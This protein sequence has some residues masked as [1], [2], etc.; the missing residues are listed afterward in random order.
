MSQNDFTIANQTFP[1]TRADI[2][3]ALQALASNNSGASAPST[4]FANQF[5]YKTGDNTLYIRNEGNDADITVMVLDQ[6][7]DTVE[8][9][10]SDSIRTALIEFTDGDD[11]LAIADGG[12]LTTAGNLSIGGSNNELRFYE[13]ANYVGFEAPALSADKIW[14]LP[15]ADGTS[16]QALVTNGSGTLS[17]ADSGGGTSARI[18]AKPMIINGSMEINQRGTI[19]GITGAG[20]YSV[21]MIRADIRGGYGITMSQEADAPAG[22]GL[23]KSVKLDITTADTS[24]DANGLLLWNYHFEGQDLN[25]LNYGHATAKTVTVAFWCKSN[26]TGTF[27]LNLRNQDAYHIGSLVTISVANT[28]EKKVVSFVGDTGHS[29]ASNNTEG[30]R[31]QFFLNGGS[32]NIDGGVPST[33]QSTSPS[34]KSYNGT[35]DLGGSTSDNFF[36]TGLQMEVGEYTASDMPS[37]Q[38][39]TYG[40]N[41]ARC[42]RYCQST[43]SQGTAIGSATAVGIQIQNTNTTGPGSMAQGVF[44][45][46]VMRAV[47]TIVVHNQSGANTG[48]ARR[49]DT[50]GLQGLASGNASTSSIHFEN[51]GGTSANI[52]LQWQFSA[53][54]TI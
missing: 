48:N 20:V 31:V 29:L 15:T 7:N 34:T 22:Y 51:S 41:L 21:D 3:S 44:L 10:K 52:Q 40:E 5:F 45:R 37:F 18:N 8:Y 35:I 12:A 4:Q 28:W 25:M 36:V 16:G 6:T 33:W 42:E 23:T 2:N 19:T 32:D 50:G 30:F 9:F 54:S 43:F 46:T 53:T 11:A 17:F 24:P 14:V 39:E 13:G 47:P 38:H 1:N 27:Q 49:G 26:K